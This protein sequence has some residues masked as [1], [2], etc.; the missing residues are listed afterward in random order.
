MECAAAP[1]AFLSSEERGER[2]KGSKR[3]QKIQ[4]VKTHEIFNLGPALKFALL[5]LTITIVSKLALEFFGNSGFLL[6][7]ALGALAGLDAVM[8]NTAQLAGKTI[9]ARLGVIAFLLANAIN[10]S[11][12]S[13]YSFLQ[14]NRSFAMQLTAGMVI[15]IITS[16][17]GLFFV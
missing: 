2:K 14:G 7:T 3:E 5:F 9:D 6:T 13:V 15:I 10:L 1:I 11:A 12:K 17:F 4:A 16:L 8:I